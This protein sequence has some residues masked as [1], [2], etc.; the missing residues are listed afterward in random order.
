MKKKFITDNLDN[1]SEDVK[2]LLTKGYIKDPRKRPT[3]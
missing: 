2:D 3:I 1:V